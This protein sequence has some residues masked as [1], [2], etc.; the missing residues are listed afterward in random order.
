MIRSFFLEN[1]Y[2]EIYYFDY[3]NQ[4]II[5]QVS[6]LGFS[7]D[8]KYLQYHRMYAKSEYQIPLTEITETLI[9]LKGYQGYKTFVDYLSKSNKEHK[10]HY[11]TPA[12]KAYTYVDVSNLSKAEL[13][14]GTI[15][16]QIIFK[17]LS[18][19]IKE[20]SYEI[21]ANGSSYGKVYPYQYPF[22]YANSYQGITH[23]NNQGLDEAPLNIEIYGAFLNPEITVKKNGTIIQ[24]LKLYV[25]S[26][27]ATLTV[28]SNPSEQVIQMIE[29]GTTYDIYGMQDFEAD[30]F[31]FIN[32]GDYEIE[33][34]PGVSLPS[35]CRVTLFEGYMGI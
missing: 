32:H 9:F 12:F 30:N 6:G 27:D 21:I 14:S 4:T 19:W 16:S 28:I 35:A 3:R 24:K 25:E 31:L 17:K 2:G 10:L 15:Q 18:L 34:K 1:E 23:I 13:V 5:T 33:F 8:I 22:I 29:N 7:L 26:D 11:T 20:K